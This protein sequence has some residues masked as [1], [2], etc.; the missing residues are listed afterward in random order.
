MRRTDARAPARS[1]SR[2]SRA[3]ARGYPAAP[4]GTPGT[5]QSGAGRLSFRLLVPSSVEGLQTRRYRL[6]FGPHTQQVA[7]P[8][9]GNLRLG[10][11]AAH[12]LQCHVEGFRRAV[13]AG[14]AATAV[15]I[16]RDA[17]MVDADQLHG[18]VDVVDEVRD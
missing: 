3:P 16:G 11:A 6:D 7:A 9:P 15:E 10:I 17:D 5:R 1:P 18:I 12:Q 13:P 8:Q 4:A 2:S 14:D